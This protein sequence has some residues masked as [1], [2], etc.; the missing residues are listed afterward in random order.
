MS[1][2]CS[3]AQKE[4]QKG[5]L[6]ALSSVQPKCNAK[7]KLRFIVLEQ[8]TFKS[9]GILHAYESRSG[10]THSPLHIYHPHPAKT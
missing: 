4:S 1:K 6:T 9:H 8:Y 5:F 2:I 3:I 10:F 7:P